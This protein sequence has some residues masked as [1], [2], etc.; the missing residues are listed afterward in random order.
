MR[1][2]IERHGGFTGIVKS[3]VLD[4]STLPETGRTKVQSLIEEAGFFSSEELTGQ[5]AGKPD[6]FQ[7]SIT[8][9]ADDGM[10]R[11]AQYGES[12]LPSAVRELIELARENAGQTGARS[13]DE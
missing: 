6:R 10:P 13:R 11:T 5:I 2:I 7:Y 1:V 9:V 4:T 8:V 3:T 12:G